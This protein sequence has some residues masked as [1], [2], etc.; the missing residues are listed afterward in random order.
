MKR[1][2]MTLLAA[3]VMTPTLAMAADATTADFTPAQQ[4]AI[5]KIAADYMVAH[6]EILVQVSQKLQAQQAAQQ[7]QQA[8]DAVLANAKALV[9]DPAT[10][11]YGPKDAKVAFVEFFD[12]QCLYCSR[13]A[14]LVEQT[15]KA[16][17]TVRF[18]FK[19]W[20]IF[21]DRWKESITA[22]ETGMAVWKEKGSQAYFDYHNSLYRTGH[23]E[24]KLTNADI[25]AAVKAA[26]ASTPSADQLKATHEAL[27]SNDELARTLGFGG[28]PGFVVMPTS[29]AT[30]ENTTVL[31]GAVS[32]EELQAAIVKAQG[33]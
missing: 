20:P 27:A 9:N 7:Q 32:A 33:K 19:E 28:T 3:L 12:Y 1:Q 24:G 18:V 26:K 5:G 29:G 11:S 15:V 8:Q 30:A 17:P 16:N 23:D 25:A 14:P 4:E 6:P 10:P 22:A 13:M 21:G 31:P 2:T